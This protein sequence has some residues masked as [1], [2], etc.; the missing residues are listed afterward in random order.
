MLRVGVK[1]CV[2]ERTIWT[3]S[4]ILKHHQGIPMSKLRIAIEKGE[5]LI[6]YSQNRGVELHRKKYHSQQGKP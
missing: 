3:C 5:A 1:E 2:V 6:I 4:L